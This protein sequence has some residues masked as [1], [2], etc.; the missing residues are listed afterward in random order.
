[1]EP[2]E[3]IIG[4]PVI[5]WGVVKSNGQKLCPTETVIESEPWKLGHGE[6]V[7]KVKGKSGGV[8]ISHLEL[9]N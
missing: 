6:M 4:T 8:S 9:K 5:Y 1:M 3:I 2:E 7:C